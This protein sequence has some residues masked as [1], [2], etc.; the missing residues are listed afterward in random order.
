MLSTL[1]I[2]STTYPT[3]KKFDDEILNPITNLS[4]KHQN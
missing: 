1:H 2:P 3:L 4:H